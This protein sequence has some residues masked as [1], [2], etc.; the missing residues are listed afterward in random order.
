MSLRPHRLR[1][2]SP[3]RR[4]RRSFLVCLLLAVVFASSCTARYA[5]N[6]ARDAADIFTV[7]AQTGSYGVAARVGPLKAGLNYKSP[8]GFAGGLRG[9]HFGRHYSAEFT[10]LFFGAD[11]FGGEPMGDLDPPPPTD[12]D[13]PEGATESGDDADRLAPDIPGLSAL[14]ESESVTEYTPPDGADAEEVAA[15]TVEILQQRGKAF[16]SRSPFG[17]EHAAHET[18]SLLK[19]KRAKFSPLYYFTQVEV[20]VGLYVGLK[21][22]VNIGEFVDFLLGFVGID[23][24]DDDEPFVPPRLKQ[25]RDSPIWQRLDE[26]TKRDILKQL[27]E[28]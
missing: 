27:G 11:Y 20:T 15:F 6:R 10:A 26:K 3:R 14:N 9:G 13:P 28:Q 7:E 21:V 25:L 2:P 23:I 4:W 16:R 24:M 22:G 8:R 17:T 5:R 1:L 12:A 18:R 19:D